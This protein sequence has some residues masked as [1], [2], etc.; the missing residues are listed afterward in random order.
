MDELNL[1]IVVAIAQTGSLSKAAHLLNLSQPAV[2]KRLVQLESQLK[3]RLF[4]R[5]SKVVIPTSEGQFF[6]ERAK[7]ILSLLEA[8]LQDLRSQQHS[9]QG[10]LHLISSYHVGL[11]YLQPLLQTFIQQHPE[12]DL[13]WQWQ[14]SEAAI[15]QI[16]HGQADMAI[17][18]C[19]LVSY[20]D[21]N[22]LPIW[23]EKLLPVVSQYHPL[24][25]HPT[26]TVATLSQYKALLPAPNTFTRTMTQAKFAE[27]NV[28]LTLENTVNS[29][30]AIQ[31]MVATG[32]G[33]SLLPEILIRPP[34]VSLPLPDLYL[35]RELGIITHKQRV[36][37]FAAQELIQYIEAQTEYTNSL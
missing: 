37:A 20:Q 5:L 2:S 26:L 36:R 3:C 11:N 12:L 17:T 33:W 22:I 30:Q 19:P 8:T 29:L 4:D 35:Q 6:I 16:I 23:Q 9:V 13:H 1:K 10:R 25:Q 18:T 31:Y 32:L 21:L 34:L 7:N 15:E 28:R 24:N 27:A 14:D